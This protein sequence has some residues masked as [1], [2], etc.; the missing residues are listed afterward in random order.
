MERR[1]CGKECVLF[2][3]SVLLCDSDFRMY[4]NLHSSVL[5]LVTLSSSGRFVYFK[6]P[7]PKQPNQQDVSTFHLHRLTVLYLQ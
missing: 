6:G 3:G 4:E 7:G 5:T 1:R 2:I